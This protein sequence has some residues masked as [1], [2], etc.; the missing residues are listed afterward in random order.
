MIHI[1]KSLKTFSSTIFYQMKM[2]FSVYP[3][4]TLNKKEQAL[5]VNGKVAVLHCMKLQL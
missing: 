4:E 5:F 2:L 3:Q 1:I